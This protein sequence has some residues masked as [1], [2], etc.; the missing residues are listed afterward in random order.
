LNDQEFAAFKRR[1]LGNKFIPVPPPGRN[2]SA[3]KGTDFLGLGV[4]LLRFLVRFG[5]QPNSAVL[6]I[7]CGVGR[8]AL[9]LTQYLEERGRYFGFDI[10]L[11]AI[12]WCH[13]NIHSRYPNFRFAVLNARNN[14]YRNQYEF[15][16][17]SLEETELPIPIKEMFDQAAAFSVFTHLLWPEVESYFRKIPARLRPGGTFVSTWFLMNATKRGGVSRGLSRFEFDL[18][19]TGPTF[20][21][22]RKS[23]S[24]AIAHSEEDVIALA[25]QNGFEAVAVEY[26]D[27]HLGKPGQDTLVLRKL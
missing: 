15:G 20:L 12:S 9:P 14:H 16:Q 6:D 17:Q 27:W 18:E 5:L 4:V 1:V 3:Q 22:R 7:G 8:L 25:R 26:Q 21:I 19:S 13:E 2:Q 10:N 23:Y 11:D 24:E